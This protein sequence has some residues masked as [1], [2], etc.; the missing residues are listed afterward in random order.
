MPFLTQY[1]RDLHGLRPAIN[2]VQDPEL[3]VIRGKNFRFKLS[4]PYSGWGNGVEIDHLPID[5]CEYPWIATAMVQ[6]QCCLLTSVGVFVYDNC[7]WVN[8]CPNKPMIWENCE[9]NEYPWSMAFVGAAWYFSHPTFGIAF[10]DVD[11]CE[12]GKCDYTTSYLRDDGEGKFIDLT[13]GGGALIADP[14][15]GITQSNNRLIILAR[16][17][18]SWSRIDDGCDI[19][20][21]MYKGIG[22]Q[23]LS[24]NHYGKP[25]AV[26]QTP[27]GFI[28]Y[29]TNGATTFQIR[30]DEASF[31]VDHLTFS[32]VPI[33]PYAITQH[34][35]K[36][37]Y[38]LS[39]TGLYQTDGNYPTLFEPFIGKWLADERLQTQQDLNS[40]NSI[41]MFYSG[42]SNELFISIND[43][44]V[45]DELNVY[46]HSIVFQFDY[47]KWSS[48]DQPHRFIGAT[49]FKQHRTNQKSLGFISTCDNTIRSFDNSKVNGYLEKGLDSYIQLGLI[50][51]P[52]ENEIDAVRELQRVNIYGSHSNVLDQ[53]FDALPN[54]VD[55]YEENTKLSSNYNVTLSATHD[56]YSVRDLQWEDAYLQHSHNFSNNYSC[57][58]TGIYFIIKI[59]ANQSG[60]YYDISG[61]D[62]K[63]YV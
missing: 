46:Q 58:I 55:G 24:V 41:R 63:V 47:G 28:T 12:W 9:D 2:H 42:E 7:E 8:V 10:Y 51:V 29:T 56:G 16:D 60:Q 25:L 5:P 37:N 50:N 39:K 27:R 15:Y 17:T 59:S 49:N 19:A 3:G 57:L 44:R 52:V 23:N 31:R 20:A 22:F 1:Y 32:M 13:S 36:V 35:S 30:E 6:D 45:N 4:G 62:A 48:F 61:L 53:K 38:F 11:K 18:V 43:A 33:S 14:I 40:V 54:E 34:D 21:D 26:M